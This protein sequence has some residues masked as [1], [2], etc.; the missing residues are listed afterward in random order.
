M[1]KSL[2]LF[3]TCCSLLCLC[4]FL[5]ISAGA[6]IFNSNLYTDIMQE[7][8]DLTCGEYTYVLQEDGTAKITHYQTKEYIYVP[9]RNQF[10]VDEY[11]NR[12]VLYLP[13][14][15]DGHPV[16]SVASGAFD[17][18]SFDLVQADVFI[19]NT[20]INLEPYAFGDVTVHRFLVLPNHPKYMVMGDMLYEKDTMRLVD[21]TGA[22]SFDESCDTLTIPEGTRIIGGAA[23]AQ[24]QAKEIILPESLECIEDEV[25][26][27]ARN[28]EKIVIPEGVWH[29]GEAAFYECVSLSEVTMPQSL[30]ELGNSAF[31]MCLALEQI[32]MPADIKVIS[33]GAFAFCT[34]LQKVNMVSG[35][36]IVGEGAFIWCQA[37]EK[38]ELPSTVKHV[39]AFAFS[40]C[41]AL[42]D[43]NLPDGLLTLG[44]G[45]FSGSALR[46][47]SLP[48]S[49]TDL[50][51]KAEVSTLLYEG[52]ALGNCLKLEHIL[53]SAD[54][55][56]F[57]VVDG[58][59]IRK[60]DNR[61]MQYP[62]AAQAETYVV[63]EGVVIIGNH[64]FAGNLYLK[65]VV[66]SEGVA[67]IE[68]GAF[69]DCQNLQELTL[70]LSLDCQLSREWFA[71][72]TYRVTSNVIKNCPQLKNIYIT[73]GLTQTAYYEH[74]QEIMALLNDACAVLTAEM[75]SRQDV[76]FIPYVLTKEEYNH[77]T[78]QMTGKAK[79]QT[80][81]CYI[82]ITA[83]KLEKM[84]DAQRERYLDMYPTLIGQDFYVLTDISD[85]MKEKMQEY[86]ADVGYTKEAFE[87]SLKNINS[88]YITY[89]ANGDV[90]K[91][92]YYP[93]RVLEQP[94]AGITITSQN[95]IVESPDVDSNDGMLD[96]HG[97]PVF[98]PSF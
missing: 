41:S 35:L 5:P 79:K 43:I 20:M 12:V 11:G 3:M 75:E 42:K 48:N 84:N 98:K 83:E 78:G 28:L 91:K 37:L 60:T 21:W 67:T 89:V 10:S 15:L 76:Y 57:T 97:L 72:G 24:V 87:K 38:M 29:I 62:I 77:Y 59:L 2:L 18:Y 1:K 27:Q 39:G 96:R 19:P 63:P 65:K 88:Q 49:L 22:A 4:C 36:E 25:F 81:S 68:D 51:V 54:H 74:E 14:E 90:E 69:R 23:F 45:A 70:P 40:G 32:E 71:N 44:E 58:A 26:Y 50:G 85:S 80:T 17:G 55:P 16:T 95:P 92:C 52:A 86:F 34:S 94:F 33:P 7:S 31:Y 8:Q 64:S 47:I 82:K 13:E 61:L 6:A 93:S 56:M 9:S 53:V 66:I 73:E 30:R 46:E